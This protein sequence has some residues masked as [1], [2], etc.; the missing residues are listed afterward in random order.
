MSQAHQRRLPPQQRRSQIITAARSHI[1][2]RGLA[3]TSLRDI[4]TAAGVSMGT[5]SYHF[6]GI[7]EIL[8]AV[9]IA[10]AEEF[11]G[12]A[13]TLADAASDPW[14]A[15][16][17]LI[18]PMF[19]DTPEVEA[20][21]R[22]WAHFWAAVARR[23]RMADTYADRIRHWESCCARVIARGIAAGVFHGQDPDG[24]ALQ[25]AAYSDGLGTQ[26]A[27]RP[28]ALPAATARQWMHELAQLLLRRQ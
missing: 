7:D 24:I 27:Q 11:Y 14:D 6:A 18:D 10:E 20:H 26:R 22:I 19:A 28:H 25:M 2:E 4:A 21:W 5:V 8:S 9:V 12:P 16:A 1:A 3:R 15:L 13:V 23:P 17:A